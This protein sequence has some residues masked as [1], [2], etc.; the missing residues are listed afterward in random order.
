MA[1]IMYLSLKKLPYMYMYVIFQ[2]ILHVCLLDILNLIVE[3]LFSYLNRL[4]H[5]H[6]SEFTL[7]LT[8]Y[9]VAL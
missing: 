7:D 2:Q 3:L 6:V 8:N 9:E 5:V 4:L 1:N